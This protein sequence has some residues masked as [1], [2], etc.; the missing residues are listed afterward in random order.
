MKV[1]DKKRSILQTKGLTK[2][3]PGVLAVDNVD[4]DL[5]EGE[6]HG[7]VGENG[8][9]KS[10]FVKMIDGSYKPDDGKIILN[11]ETI[12]IKSPQ[13]SNLKG[14]GMVHQELMLLPHLSIKENICISYL[15]QNNIKKVNWKEIHNIAEKQL[16]KLGV[17]Y[18]LDIVNSEC[19]SIF[20]G[21]VK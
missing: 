20:N 14:I 2:R 12:N 6:V 3:F 17:N 1:E 7:L 4:F 21:Y 8:A 13:D 5:L 16:Y 18:N 10:T 9:G 19:S 11:G 15:I